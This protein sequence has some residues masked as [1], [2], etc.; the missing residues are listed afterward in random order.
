[1]KKNKNNIKNEQNKIRTFFKALEKYL[2]SGLLIILPIGITIFLLIK[3][4]NFLDSLL[5]DLFKD[6]LKINIPGLG[7]LATIVLLLLVGLIANNVLGK[8]LTA[9]IER[10]LKKTP[11]VKAIYNPM[12]EIVQNFS[13]KQSNSFRKVVFIEFPMKG[14]GS[15]GF[16]TKESIIVDGEEKAAVFIPTTPNPTNGFL[17]YANSGEYTELDISVDDALKTII[18]LGSISPEI[19]K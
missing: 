5:G 14:K 2:V 4:F 11:L 10:L 17:I 16:I 13:G 6:Y 8:K 9:G 19:L 15:I 12:K 18:S 7:L 1:M 3:M